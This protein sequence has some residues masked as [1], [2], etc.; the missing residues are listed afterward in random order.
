MAW[1]RTTV[2]SPVEEIVAEVMVEEGEEVKKGDLLAQLASRKEE[3]EVERLDQ[4]IA[5]AQFVYD[6]TKA[7]YGRKSKVRRLFLRRSRIWIR[8]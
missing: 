5:K 3:L 8:P 4:L 2:S 1:H 6:A 7:L